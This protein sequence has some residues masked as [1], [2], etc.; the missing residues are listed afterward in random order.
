[1]NILFVCTGNT[2]RSAMAEGIFRDMLKNKNINNINV[3]SA[4]ISAFEG[5]RANDKAA[6]ALM[7]NNIDISGHKARQLTADMIKNSGLVLTMTKSHKMMILNAFPDEKNKTFTLKEYAMAVSGENTDGKNL[8]IADPFGMDYNV[9]KK[10]ML[11]IKSELIK[12][13]NNIDKIGD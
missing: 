2:C 6:E 8:D 13:I 4:G 10:C 1:M 7:E 11:E 12:I 5:D 3:S 9:Y